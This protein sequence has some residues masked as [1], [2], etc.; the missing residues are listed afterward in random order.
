MAVI[1]ISLVEVPNIVLLIG[2]TIIHMKNKAKVV[3]IGGGVVE[4]VRFTTLQKGWSD[5]V[6]CERKELTSGSTGTCWF[7]AFIQHELLCWSN[8]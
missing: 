1:G 8:P 3:V 7:D 2:L 4:L 5:V 6:L